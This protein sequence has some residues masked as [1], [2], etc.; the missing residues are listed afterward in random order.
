VGIYT[1]RPMTPTVM[2]EQ[3]T[4]KNSRAISD[5]NSF[6]NEIKCESEA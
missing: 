2:V 3:I 5:K 1:S 4:H 6:L